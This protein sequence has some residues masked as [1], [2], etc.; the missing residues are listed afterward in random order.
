MSNNQILKLLCQR[1]VDN[2]FD[3]IHDAEQALE[4]FEDLATP[5]AVLGLFNEIECKEANRADEE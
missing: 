5:G 1:L 4:Q 3:H 2:Q